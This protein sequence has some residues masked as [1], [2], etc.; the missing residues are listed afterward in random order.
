MTFKEL[1]HRLNSYIQRII[2]FRK[3]FSMTQTIVRIAK[4]HA[5]FQAAEGVEERIV[6]KQVWEQAQI[7]QVIEFLEQIRDRM[8]AANKS[9]F[10][11]IPDQKELKPACEAGDVYAAFD[12][13][14]RVVAT[15]GAFHLAWETDVGGPKL[16]HG[17]RVYDYGAACVDPRFGGLAPYTLQD[18]FFWLRTL[19]LLL[20]QFKARG[21]I[22]LLVSVA[23]DN[24]PSLSCIQ[25]NFFQEVDQVPE[26]LAEV[27]SGWLT[28]GRARH[29][30]LDSNGV[31]A[32]AKRFVNAMQNH[33][34]VSRIERE[35]GATRTIHVDL[36]IEWFSKAFPVITQ[37]VRGE[38]SLDDCRFSRTPYHA[39]VDHGDPL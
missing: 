22:C 34:T 23:E 25:R 30:W 1:R 29:F 28:I 11:P 7:T 9:F 16:L 6:I 33:T 35:S 21:G 36:D 26:W 13:A 17:V 31:L 14:G 4:K 37:I 18:M 19:G 3:Y 12:T 8:L 38:I 5:P 10:L 24:T 20:T 15:G 2:P 32:Q 27:S 39:M